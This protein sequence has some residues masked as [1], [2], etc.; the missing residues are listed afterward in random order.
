MEEE[1]AEENLEM[2]AVWE[3]MEEGD[4]G[5]TQKERGGEAQKEVCKEVLTEGVDN[6][7]RV[8]EEGAD[9][10]E[11]EVVHR[12]ED[13]KEVEHVEEE[14]SGAAESV[15]N[16]NPNSR[17]L[18]HSHRTTIQSLRRHKFHRSK[19]SILPS[20]LRLRV[21][22]VGEKVVDEMEGMVRT[23]RRFRIMTVAKTFFRLQHIHSHSEAL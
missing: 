11:E 10:K 8:E 22:R 12:E 15:A 1:G 3:D 16:H 21:L 6:Q 18:S 4:Q 19:N 13:R 9:T 7:E 20:T 5:H 14:D 17:V 23:A 2:E